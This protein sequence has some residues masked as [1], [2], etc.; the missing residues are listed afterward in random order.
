MNEYSYV[1]MNKTYL[2]AER[3]IHLNVS[4][5]SFWTSSAFLNN[6]YSFEIRLLQMKASRLFTDHQNTF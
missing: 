4:K 6:S 2:F 3:A 1:F 5:I